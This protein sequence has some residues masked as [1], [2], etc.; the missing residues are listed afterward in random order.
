MC[1]TSQFTLSHL[2]LAIYIPHKQTRPQCN[3]FHWV[4]KDFWNQT[5]VRGVYSLATMMCNV[6]QAKIGELNA[7]K[8]KEKRTK[9]KI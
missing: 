4:A 1:C 9:D 7:E 2:S 8:V 6:Q 3:G 5:S